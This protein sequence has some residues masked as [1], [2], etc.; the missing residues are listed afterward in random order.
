M[1]PAFATEFE[2]R[3]IRLS[4]LLVVAFG[5]PPSG[6]EVQHAVATCIPGVPAL[7]QLM[8]TLAAGWRAR[9]VHSRPGTEGARHLDVP[10]GRRRDAHSR[11]EEPLMKSMSHRCERLA[12]LISG[13]A[14]A[15]SAGCGGATA[16]ENDQ[17]DAAASFAPSVSRSPAPSDDW[18]PALVGDPLS[19]SRQEL[20]H[21]GYG[22][23]PDPA[24]NPA[25]YAR[26][27]RAASIPA[28]RRRGAAQPAEHHL[29]GDGG[30]ATGNWAPWIG[31]VLQGYAGR[32]SGGGY[33]MNEADWNIPG[34]T[35][36]GYGTGAAWISIWNG[37]DNAN[38]L[39]AESWIEVSENSLQGMGSQRQC[40]AKT[41]LPSADYGAGNPFE[42]FT[43]SEIFAEEWYCDA[44]GNIAMWGGFAC[45]FMENETTGEVWPCDEALDPDCPSY[46]LLPSDLVVGNLGQS[47]EFVIENDSGQIPTNSPYD[48]D[49]PA[50]AQVTMSGSALVVNQTGLDDGNGFTVNVESDPNVTLATDYTSHVRSHLHIVPGTD[51]VQWSVTNIYEYNGSPNFSNYVGGCA[52]GIAVGPALGGTPNGTPWIL[53]CR[54]RQNGLFDVLQMQSGEWVTEQAG[55]GTNIAVSSDG[56]PWVLDPQGDIFFWN[57]SSFVRNPMGGCATSIAVGPSSHGLKH[58][59]PWVTGC[60]NNADGNDAVYEMQSDGSWKAMQSDVAVQLAVSPEGVP[61]ALN[62]AG[63]IL[64]WNG[65][66]FVPNPKGGCATSISVGPAIEGQPNGIPWITGCN[67]NADFLRSVYRMD[68]DGNWQLMQA[69]IASMVAVAPNGAAWAL[70]GGN[71]NVF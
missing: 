68:G 67:R 7:R 59:T 31:A 48:E 61:W 1:D 33:V 20:V 27:L 56:F 65:S 36:G 19:R 54:E 14:L 60:D 28:R 70:G 15:W 4:C 13:L 29:S 37:L 3:T 2:N 25:G 8:A 52:N 39:Q 49:W 32:P 40:F 16:S 38:L 42:P 51:W 35:L 53:G 9:W 55:V 63:A 6:I 47:A 66:K 23:R 64:F 69:D 30:L 26:W 44:V 21:S 46:Q 24:T 12:A 62:A 22:I 50:F 17:A 5:A 58:G 18:R 34:V 41:L 45:T 71:A 43:G 11:R 10:E 57:G